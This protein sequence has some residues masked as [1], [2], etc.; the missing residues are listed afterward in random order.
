[1]KPSI[2]INMGLALI[3]ACTRTDTVLGHDT[4]SSISSDSDWTLAS[5]QRALHISAQTQRAV[6]FMHSLVLPCIYQQAVSP[7]NTRYES[8]RFPHS[9]KMD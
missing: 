7:V 5:D 4:E 2:N 8:F 6:P 9:P 1:M 3:K